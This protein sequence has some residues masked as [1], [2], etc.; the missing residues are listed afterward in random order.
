ME[1]RILVYFGNGITLISKGHRLPSGKL[2]P[3]DT[4][5]ASTIDG[6]LSFE[7][8]EEAATF[9]DY[10]CPIFG[11][12]LIPETYNGEIWGLQQAAENFAKQIG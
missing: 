8:E 2:A 12:Y 5:I 9:A 7:T 11:A 10:L 6:V 4:A 1:K 3:R